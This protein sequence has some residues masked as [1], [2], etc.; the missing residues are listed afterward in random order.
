MLEDV[1]RCV[2]Q[3]LKKG[4]IKKGEPP[5][6]LSDNGSCNI[7]KDLKIFLAEEHKINHIRGKPLHPQTQGKIECYHRSIKIIVLLEN[8]YCLEQFA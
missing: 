2:N 5:K 4:N 6:L 8:Y 7:A 1:K 3:A